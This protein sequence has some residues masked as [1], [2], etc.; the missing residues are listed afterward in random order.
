MFALAG[1]ACGPAKEP[2]FPKQPYVFPAAAAEQPR[3]DRIACS[4]HIDGRR[5]S[6]EQAMKE[7][8]VQGVSAA[9][10]VQ[11]RVV[12]ARGWGYADSKRKKPMTSETVLQ[13]ASISKAISSVGVMRM[14]Q[15]GK[16]DLDVDVATYVK[17]WEARYKKRH[18]KI[19]LRQL[20]SHSAGLNVHGFSGFNGV[21]D[22]PSTIELLNGKGLST[23]IKVEIEPG[24]K[25]DYSGGG[26]TVLQAA[27]E[28]ELDVP[29]DT[30]MYEWV[31]EPFRLTHST[32]EQPIS[33][34]H[35]AFAAS[36]HDDD[37]RP[38]KNRW[39]VYPTQA[40]AGL[41]TTPTDL[42]TIGAALSAIYNGSPGPLTQAWVRLMLKPVATSQK[43]GLGWFVADRDGVIEA[44]HN[45]SNNGFTSD[46]AWRTDGSGAAVMVN[47]GGPIAKALL[48]AIG[49]EYGW[50]DRAGRGDGGC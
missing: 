7:H 49:E 28:A 26:F 45:G 42:L 22:L 47:G 24:T 14:A 33:E 10:M 43:M 44:S 48:R 50:R 6:L 36:A 25:W 8:K 3:I 32:F 31:I 20:M 39:N 12:W 1:V 35:Q 17:G 19:T 21:E 29:F 5:L 37:G 23:P 27:V 15:A 18:A 2:A 38:I 34:V 40:A 41:W 9:A 46:M 13:A 4:L 11:G 16:L 30:A